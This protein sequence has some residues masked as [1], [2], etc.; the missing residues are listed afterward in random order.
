MSEPLK[1]L[2]AGVQE[3]RS[4]LGIAAGVREAFGTV[5]GLY[6]E[7]HYCHYCKGWIEGSAPTHQVSDIQGLSGRRGTVYHCARC[8]KELA[9]FGAMA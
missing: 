1:D 6:R 5:D 7:F 2:P 9:F 3:D 8:N 4:Y